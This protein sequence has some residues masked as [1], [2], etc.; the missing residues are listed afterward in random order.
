M[1]TD[2]VWSGNQFQFTLRGQT[3]ATYIIQSS[4]DLR[5]WTPS[6][7][8]FDTQA[9]RTIAVPAAESAGFWRIQRL[10]GPLFE[11]AIAARNQVILG[12]GG[13]ID[14][15]NSTNA[16]E[17]TMGR[18]DPAKATDRANISCGLAN[19]NAVNIGNVKVLGT[20]SLE[21]S[22]TVTLGP[23]GGV[24]SSTFINNPVT[25]GMIEPGYVRDDMNYPFAAARLP[26]RYGPVRPLTPGIFEGTNYTVLLSDRDYMVTGMS[27]GAT[28][29]MLILG[30]ARI[31]VVG[32]TRVS[33]SAYILL[34]RM[35]VLNGMR[36]V[37]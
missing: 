12:G 30:N 6:V 28:Q 10:P 19:T 24:G 4:S 18:Y 9:T 14:S 27:L 21:P 37:T 3:N 8:N 11:Y 29:K 23:N 26:I 16:L 33:G 36:S 32:R 35:R 17:S 22:G 20:I 13:R 34:G 7:T 2:A 5:A 15:F 25:A 1:L 31:Y